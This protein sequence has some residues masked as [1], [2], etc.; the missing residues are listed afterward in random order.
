MRWRRLHICLIR[1]STQEGLT[2]DV[3]FWFLA[4]LIFDTERVCQ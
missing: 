1:D 3:S 2:V 4:T